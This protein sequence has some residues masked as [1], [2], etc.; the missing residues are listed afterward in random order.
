MKRKII[1]IVSI[2]IIVILLLYLKS[3]IKKNTSFTQGNNINT[4]IIYNYGTSKTLKPKDKGFQ[5]ILEILNYK[6]DNAVSQ[7]EH[8]GKFQVVD[9]KRNSLSIELV[10]NKEESLSLP[11]KN[12]NYNR[13]FFPLENNLDSSNKNLDNTTFYIGLDESYSENP[14]GHIKQSENLV[15]TVT[16]ALS[17]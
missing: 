16:W 11:H 12:L 3:Y 9:L 17:Q 7:F 5:E 13:I 6:F 2:F 15:D 8:K 10:F 1:F 14:L 4:I